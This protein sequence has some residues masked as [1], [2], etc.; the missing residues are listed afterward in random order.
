MQLVICWPGSSHLHLWRQKSN[1]SSNFV[2]QYLDVRF[3]FILTRTLLENLLSV[4]VT[5]SNYLLMSPDI[6]QFESGICNERN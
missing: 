2:T 3:G 5:H 4:A 1:C 6:H